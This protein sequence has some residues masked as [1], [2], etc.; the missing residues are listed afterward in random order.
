MDCQECNEILP[1]YIDASLTPE[2][3]ETV[4]YHLEKCR[5]CSEEYEKLAQTLKLV[6]R[7]KCVEAPA[8]FHSRF[9]SRF[10][11]ECKAVRRWNFWMPLSL[12]AVAAAAGILLIIVLYNPVNEMRRNNLPETR[13][14]RPASSSEKV[15]APAKKVTKAVGSQI[16]AKEKT[17]FGL[18]LEQKLNYQ[19]LAE[20]NQTIQSPYPLIKSV[21]VS[22]D[23]ER[24]PSRGPGSLRAKYVSVPQQPQLVRQTGEWSGDD[25]AIT[26][27]LTQVIRSAS[28][29]E[30]LWERAKIKSITMPHI[31]WRRQMLGTIFLGTQPGQG[32]EIRLK[33][34]QKRTENWI[35]KYQ[36]IRPNSPDISQVTQPFLIFILPQSGQ[37]VV[38]NEE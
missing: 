15:L 31:D 22:A 8:D 12:G 5:Q 18:P 7:L 29:L 36:V 33:E 3:I 9:M 6:G 11:K 32:Y 4:K 26:E 14:E 34:F 25:C 35:V 37:P 38:F 27:P 13:V 24:G 2:E 28:E 21:A 19:A 30:A 20:L 10:D 1:L 23:Y 16:A 17:K